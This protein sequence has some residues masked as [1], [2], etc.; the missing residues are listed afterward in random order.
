MEQKVKIATDSF[1]LGLLFFWQFKE[2]QEGFKYSQPNGKRKALHIAQL[3][4]YV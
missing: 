2:K 1:N 3:Y 4:V